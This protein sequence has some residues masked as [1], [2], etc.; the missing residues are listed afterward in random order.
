MPITLDKIRTLFEKPLPS[1]LGLVLSGGGVRSAYQAGSIKY[2][3][4]AFPEV[5]FPVLSGV[6]AGAINAAHL[7]NRSGS[8]KEKASTLLE[9][10]QNITIDQV[11]KPETTIHFFRR[12]MREG[13]GKPP[14]LFSDSSQQKGLVDTTPLKAFL[15]EH[16]RTNDGFLHGIAENIE[17]EML[18]A[19]AITATNYM[20][21]RTTTF[22]Q[23]SN[24]EGWNRPNRVGVNTQLTVDHIMASAAL[25]L[26]FPAVRIGND[27]YGDGGVRLTMPLSPAINLG[28]TSIL[29]ISTR[30][31]KS[32]REAEEQMVVGYPPAAQVIGLLMNAI[33]L[34]VL[35]QDAMIM[36][37]IN[38]LVNEL[39]KRKRKGLRPINFLML[40]PSVDIGKLAGEFK[41]KFSGA[42]KWLT[43]GLGSGETKSPD[44]LSMLLFEEEYTERLIEIGY[45]DTHHQHDDLASFFE[46]QEAAASKTMHPI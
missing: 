7:A 12:I 29:V 31:G 44:W 17:K 46:K 9:Y 28:A 37:R 21:G 45:E 1:T 16:F 36:N 20:T 35:D 25:P 14:G 26:L 42:L 10:W 23:G 33:F 40:R 38:E 41:P 5:R 6:S 39:P 4:E 43:M 18:Q 8:F 22:V 30:Y 27:W 3:S 24:I 15:T 13:E 34:D 11:I 32:A 2:I 19:I